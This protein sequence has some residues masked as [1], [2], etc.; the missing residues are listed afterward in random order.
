MGYLDANKSLKLTHHKEDK[1]GLEGLADSEWGNSV[2][3]RSSTGLMDRYNK[4]MILWRSKMQKILSPLH[5]RG[6]VLCCIRD[7]TEIMY[8][9]N[10][11]QNM[12]F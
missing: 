7:G 3:W 5:C 8:L 9:R 11:L 6:R 2:S 12:G 10:M 1:G 4:G